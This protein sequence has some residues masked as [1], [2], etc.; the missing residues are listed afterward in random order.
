M[1]AH[2]RLASQ[3]AKRDGRSAAPSSIRIV[4]ADDHALM[5]RSLRQLLESEE[6][7]DVIEEAED[8]ALVVRHVRAHRPDVLVL[9]LSMPGGS[10]VEAIG[11]LRASVPETQIVV[12]TME[13]NPAFAQRALAAGALGFVLK[14][15]ADAELP[16][17]VRAAARDEEY[18]SPNV[19]VRLEGLRQSLTEDRLTPRETEVLRLLALGHTSVEIAD[20]LH[21]SPRT[22]E[23][24]RTRIHRK[25]GLTTRAEL[26][27][28]ALGCGLLA[29]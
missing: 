18:I 14:D 2:L 20:K 15:R 22:I 23:T 13:E 4:L 5:R 27:R 12:L 11:Q 8:L 6:D 10:S 17:A 25:L 21:L 9:D 24:H 19:S 16:Q 3:P 28:Y 26:V 7:L 1:S 29:P